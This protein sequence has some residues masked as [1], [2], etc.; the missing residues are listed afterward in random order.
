[1]M[2]QSSSA[3][4]HRFLQRVYIYRRLLPQ[5]AGNITAVYSSRMNQSQRPPPTAPSFDLLTPSAIVLPQHSALPFIP[6]SGHAAQASILRS[7]ING[8]NSSG[9]LFKNSMLHGG[10]T[11]PWPA[12]NHRPPPPETHRPTWRFELIS[13]EDVCNYVGAAI[14]PCLWFYSTAH[15]IL[16]SE[17]RSVSAPNCCYILIATLLADAPCLFCMERWTHR[18]CQECYEAR[19]NRNDNKSV[20]DEVRSFLFSKE[21]F[22]YD[23]EG[24]DIKDYSADWWPC[25]WFNF[26]CYQTIYQCVCCKVCCC[27]ES[28]DVP[29]CFSC[30]CGLIY[31]ACVC[32]ITFILRRMR[33]DS[34]DYL[35]PCMQTLLISL[36]C[37]PCSI[38]QTYRESDM[39]IKSK[40]NNEKRSQTKAPPAANSMGFV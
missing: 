15:A 33:V 5:K 34:S 2:T 37:A 3:R 35:E 18:A 7:L 4:G 8:W 26:Y 10:P 22:L 32:P 25:N 19:G 21:H 31:P 6:S 1:M 27:E 9:N 16:D 28:K 30:L 29:L 40:Q 20:L 11:S 12:M 24:F 36:F 13:S 39:I 17:E 38:V 14:C 23:D